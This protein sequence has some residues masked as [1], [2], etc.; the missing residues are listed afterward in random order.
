MKNKET[1]TP[2]DYGRWD[3]TCIKMIDEPEKKEKKSKANAEIEKLK[4]LMKVACEELVEAGLYTEG[5]PIKIQIA[6]KKGAME[7]PDNA[8]VAK[9]QEYL[10][11]AVAGSGFGAGV[12][13]SGFFSSSRGSSSGVQAKTP[14]NIDII[15]IILCIN[16]Y[17]NLAHQLNRFPVISYAFC[18]LPKVRHA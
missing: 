9:V 18:V 6:W 11:A 2:A 13:V 10:N 8:Q 4:A 1:L 14:K 15:A 5:E 12:S 3:R 7:D 17:I 16:F